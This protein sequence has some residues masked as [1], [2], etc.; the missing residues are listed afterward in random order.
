MSKNKLIVV[1]LPVLLAVGLIAL[2]ILQG[3]RP[4]GGGLTPSVTP[5]GDGSG[6]ASA[7]PA[8]PTAT[9]EESAA[10]GQAIFAR[11]CASCHG[12]QGSGGRA[13]TL[14]PASASMRGS[15]QQ[16]FSENLTEIITHGKGRMPAWGDSG[17]L[18]AEEI[19]EVVAYILSLNE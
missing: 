6:A 11:R 9:L 5:R 4:A 7:T 8:G 10:A 13:R 3:A 2:T 18:T 16:A 14:N 1:L 17:R 19:A 12:A 15:G